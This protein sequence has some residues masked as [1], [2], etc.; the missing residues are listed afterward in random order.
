MIL[1]VQD[2]AQ[3]FLL[4]LA[5]RDHQHLALRDGGAQANHGALRKHDYR[6]RI[7]RKLLQLFRLSGRRCNAPRTL[8]ANRNFQRQR[9][10]AR[11]AGRFAR[12]R[13]GWRSGCVRTT[14]LRAAYLCGLVD[15]VCRFASRRHRSVGA[16]PPLPESDAA[17]QNSQALEGYCI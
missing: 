1:D 3:H 13:S 5:I 2:R 12:F 14:G 11:S 8:H 17:M 4:R 16:Y 6:A 15:Y 10:R 7:F 9:V